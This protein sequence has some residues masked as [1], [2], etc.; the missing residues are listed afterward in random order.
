MKGT[1]TARFI[2]QSAMVIVVAI[3]L[4]GVCLC[5]DETEGKT[6]TS[7]L[8]QSI[9]GFALIGLAFWL[10]REFMRKGIIPEPKDNSEEL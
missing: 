5:A 6:L 7:Y 10:G 8:L 1:I 4:F 3:F 9:G 2:G